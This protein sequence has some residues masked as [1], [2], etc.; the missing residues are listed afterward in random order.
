M[1]SAKHILRDLIVSYFKPG[2]FYRIPLGGNRGKYIEYDPAMNLDMMLGLHEPNTFE[3]FRQL[4]R[5][6]MTVVDIGAHRGYFSIY[7]NDLVGRDGIVYAFEP[8]PENYA[9]LN[10]T[11]A[12]NDCQQVRGVQKA[13]TNENAPVSLFLSH[14][15]YMSS[16]AVEW[17]GEE[18]GKTKVEG[19]RLE[20]FLEF[21]GRVPDFIK[22]DIE[23]SGIYALPDM[24]NLIRSCQ[25][26][27]LVESHLP[28]EDR[29][30]GQALSIAEYEVF[31]VGSKTPVL[32]LTADYRDRYGVWGTIVGVSKKRLS[33][34]SGFDPHRFQRWRPG[35]RKQ[36]YSS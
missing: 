17:A 35:R 34:L 31:R 9:A 12:R 20:T 18:G 4:V 6:G 7:L 5:Q 22:M 33:T 2:V 16:L 26:Y 3:V 36:L 28:A 30:I 8:M 25:P 27:L 14:T 10:R 1:L 19:T 13:I 21:E 24:A 15:P 29:A 32:N 11:L 23:G